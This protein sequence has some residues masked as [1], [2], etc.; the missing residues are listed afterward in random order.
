MDPIPHFETDEEAAE[1]WDTHSF[2]DYFDEFEPVPP[3]M[4]SEVVLVRERADGAAIPV[5]SKAG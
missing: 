3:G 5:P 2:V 4:F 1:F